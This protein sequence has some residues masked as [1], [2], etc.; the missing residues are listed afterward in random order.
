VF[1]K[2]AEQWKKLAWNRA[3]SNIPQVIFTH[4]STIVPFLTI[5][6]YVV[7]RIVPKPKRPNSSRVQAEKQGTSPKLKSAE[8]GDDVG[9]NRTELIKWTQTGE[10]VGC[11]RT[12]NSRSRAELAVSRVV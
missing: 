8:C 1:E 3:L 12:P 9:Y 10:F 6:G 4:G 5:A 11:T 2:P 7:G